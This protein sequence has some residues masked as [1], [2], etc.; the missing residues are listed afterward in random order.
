M[1][2]LPKVDGDLRA[3]SQ[4]TPPQPPA[5]SQTVPLEPTATPSSYPAPLSTSPAS[6]VSPTAHLRA[7]TAA[8]I[9][10]G[11]TGGSLPTR[12]LLTFAHDHALA[13]DAVHSPFAA[14]RLALE[15]QALGT[16]TLLLE[17]AAPDRAAFLRR[18]DLGRRL[19]EQSAHTL[20][21]LPASAAAPAPDLVIIISDGL[22]ALAAERQA[23]PLLT[24]LLS[25]LSAAGWTLAPLCL[26]RHARVSIMGEVGAAC[27]AQLALIL[28]GERPGLGTPDSLGAYFEYHPRPGLTNAERNCLS[29]IR[30]AGL[31]P[32]EAADRLFALLTTARRRQVSGIGLKEEEPSFIRSIADASSAPLASSD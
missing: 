19:S 25:K 16:P 7:F 13:R 1:N 15:L 6:A 11:R 5:P 18:P 27:R 9:G 17:S 12:E 20:A 30:P 26:I 29:N 4:D 14:E 2:P 10:L 23:A 3:P 31:P 28:L 21:T 8:R 32:L 22:S 24:A